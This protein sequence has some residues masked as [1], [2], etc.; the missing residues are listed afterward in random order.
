M[1]PLPITDAGLFFFFS[2]T[3]DASN[4][5]WLRDQDT[6][7]CLKKPNLDDANVDLTVGF[8]ELDS[9]NQ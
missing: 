7:V 3:C 1:Q 2:M 5:C 4:L 6:H 8:A 9:S